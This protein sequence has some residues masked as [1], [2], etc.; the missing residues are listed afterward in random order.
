M[1]RNVSPFSELIT[2]CWMF[3]VMKIYFLLFSQNGIVTKDLTRLKMLLSEIEVSM[4]SFLSA[5]F[6]CFYKSCN[7]CRQVLRMITFQTQ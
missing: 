4:S 1:D 2:N 3:F 5:V 7:V 6:V